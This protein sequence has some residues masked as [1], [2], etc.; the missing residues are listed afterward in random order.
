MGGSLQPRIKTWTAT[1]DVV[2]SDLNAEF[3]NVLTAMQPLLIDDYST[4]VTQMQVTTDPGE[5]G[6]E[7][8]ATTLA[9]ELARLRF[10]LK[11]ITGEA[12]WY[13]SPIASITGL[14]NA[15]GTGLTANRIVSGRVRTGSQMPIFLVPNGAARTIKLDGTPTNFIYYVDGVEYNIDADVTLTNL[16][17]APNSAN[18]CLVNDTVAADQD[19]TKYVG[20]D[21]TAIPIGAIGAEISALTGKLAAFSLNN[22]SST[23]YFIAEVGTDKLFR[24]K[25]GYFFD[26]S[27][28][29]V[30]RIVYSNNDTITLMKLTWIFAKTD[31]T[32][33]ATYNPPTWSKDE[34][35]SPAIGDYWFDTD[36]NTWKRYDVSS[37]VA[38]NA[39][40]VGVC[41]QDTT[42]TVGARSFE[43]F[44]NYAED[45]NVEIIYDSATQVKSNWYGA[46]INV[47]GYLIQNSQGLYTWSMAS[48]LDSGLTEAS[49]TFYFFYITEEGDRIISNIR[50]YDRREDLFGW[51][52]PHQSWR[53]VGWAFNNSS[54]DLEDVESYWNRMDS[55]RFTPAQTAAA[56]IEVVAHAIPLNS[57]GGAFTQTLPP[58]AFC[59]GQK[60]FFVKTSSDTNVITIDGFG[61]ETI[62]GNTTVKI[63]IQYDTLEIISDGSNWH[64]LGKGMMAYAKYTMGTGHSVSNNADT[65]LNYETKVTDRRSNVTTGASWKFTADEAMTVTATAAALFPDLAYATSSVFQ[66]GIYKNGSLL[67]YLSR[68][69]MH[70]AL[71]LDPQIFGTISLALAKDDYISFVAYQETGSS[72][73]LQSLS[74]YNY[75]TIVQTD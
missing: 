46:G 58:A 44:A 24:A 47:W 35:S 57:A 13:E 6:S 12:Q 7:I 33:T 50:P 66:M 2:Y 38:A 4:N 56:N 49:S 32:L 11:E 73:T 3:D 26:S 61:S 23:E 14:A 59:R 40:L 68:Q 65:I 69:F 36:N 54:S 52:H 9:G 20:E 43:F 42:N 48:H 71:T 75:V 29:P 18:T 74:T 10:M 70:N 21:G 34:P 25:R 51:Y 64:R 31:E 22:G 67:R 63:A 16:T 37:F 39:T 5:V 30:P 41:I 15:V 60:L 72:R 53:C 17:A 62:S 45:G 27:D 28:N 8:V 1:E 19:W 55:R